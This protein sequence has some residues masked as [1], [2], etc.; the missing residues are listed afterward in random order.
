M[1]SYQITT[2]LAVL[3][4][5][6]LPNPGQISLTSLIEFADGSLAYHIKHIDTL[7]KTDKELKKEM[8]EY[9]YGKMLVVSRNLLKIRGHG[10]AAWVMPVRLVRSN[11]KSRIKTMLMP[12]TVEDP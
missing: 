5:L 2:G 11:F 8:R 12:F 1:P 3:G 4:N 10:F 7:G 9:T 6:N